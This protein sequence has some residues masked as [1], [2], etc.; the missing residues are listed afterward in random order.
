MRSYIIHMQGNQAR[1]A[2]VAQL[3]DRLPQAQVV[4]AVNGRDV[5]AKGQVNCR[6]GDLHVPH[7]PFALSPG[8]IGCF[9]SHRK[10][11]EMIANGDD[12]FG[13]IV[14]DDMV[15]DDTLWPSAMELVHQH[16]GP[17]HMIRLPAKNREKPQSLVA[18]H[19]GTCLF[20][21]KRIGLQ[22]VAQVIGRHAARHLLAA[23]ETLDRPVDT[24]LQMH[25]IHGQTVHT[26]YPN[27]VSEETDALG[28]S[29]IQSRPTGGKLAREIKRAIY[30]TQVALRPQRP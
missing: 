29:T 19:G 25:W 12:A 1:A 5:V 7:Y 23:S 10:C 16:A 26:L 21:P 15:P 24:F 18:S 3:L 20:L 14:E 9:L 22:T 13:L 2:N 28:G 27:G 30:R 4:D 11:W 8:E 17:D 6:Q